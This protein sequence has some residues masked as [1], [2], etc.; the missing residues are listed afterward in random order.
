MKKVTMD[1]VEYTL[2]VIPPYLLPFLNLYSELASKPAQ[3]IE[4]AEKISEDMRRASQ[5]I[6]EACISPKPKPEHET[7]LFRYI[8]NLTTQAVLE[9]DSFFQR[10]KAQADLKG[11]GRIKLLDKD[12]TVNPPRPG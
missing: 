12:K 11:G 1:G 9:V 8:S 6:L 2:T 4:E 7:K 3:S 5:K 10:G